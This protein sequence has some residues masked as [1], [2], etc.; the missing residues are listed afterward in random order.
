MRVPTISTA[1]RIGLVLGAGGPLGHAFHAG[2]LR[3]LA[4][5]HGWDAR[6]ADLVVGTS[7]GAQVGALLRAGM[8]PRD[9]AA[10]VE[11]EAM[12]ADGAT[13]ARHYTRP[14]HRQPRPSQ[15]YTLAAPDY[16]RGLAR[17]PWKAR[18][19]PLVSALLPEGHVSLRAQAEG[20]RRLF[21]HRWPERRLW[22]T[23]MHLESGRRVA[24]GAP[25]APD[26]DVGTAV[27]CSGAVPG[28]CRPVRVGEHR[29]VDGGMLSPTHL[30]LLLES[31]IDVVVVSSPLSMYAPMRVLLR[32]EMRR[33]AE[34]GMTVVAIEPR[35]RTLA[36]MGL[37]PMAIER[38]AR[39]ARAAYE[40]TVR[41]V[42]RPELRL[43]RDAL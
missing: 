24:F 18:L 4:E 22:I 20:L 10:R 3:G 15:R 25:E 37:N 36:A 43:L 13:I 16:L 32:A 2:V 7:A 28:I 29:Y 38:S 34:R 17:R 27:S 31:S 23:A 12:S 14:S 11:G 40:A 19:G 9:L 6:E 42:G 26:T 8:T 35:D 33:L 5:A 21:G 1:R 39:V 41:D 30:D